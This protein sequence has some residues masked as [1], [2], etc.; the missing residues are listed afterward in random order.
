M[1]VLKS[2]STWGRRILGF[3]L[4]RPS[5]IASDHIAKKLVQVHVINCGFRILG[6]LEFNKSKT[7]MGYR[8]EG[9]S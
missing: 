9:E 7:T 4:R 6:A 1:R 3:Q 8:N 2:D 5:K